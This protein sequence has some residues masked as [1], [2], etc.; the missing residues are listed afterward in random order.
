MKNKSTTSFKDDLEISLDE[1]KK[2]G[3]EQIFYVDITRPEIDI[4]VV[5]VIIPG[6]EVYAVDPERM[7][8]RIM[9]K[10]IS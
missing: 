2:V 7:G 4:P 3:I 10:E 6:L 8:R 5:R 9:D 1:L